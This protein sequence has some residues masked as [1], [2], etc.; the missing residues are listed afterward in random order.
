MPGAAADLSALLANAT[1]GD[2]KTPRP[3]VA[4]IVRD[5]VAT[6]VA[7]LLGRPDT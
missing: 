2:E 6:P 5:F 4:E 1:E 7:F 3:V